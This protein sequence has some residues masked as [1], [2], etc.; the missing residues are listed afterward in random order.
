M[1]LNSS[2][3]E[4]KVYHE[5]LKPKSH[6]FSYGI[7]NFC[8]DLDELEDLSKKFLFFSNEKWNLFSFYKRDHLDF[9]RSSHKENILYFLEQNKIQQNISKIFLVTNLRVLGYT[10]NPVCFYYCYNSLNELECILIEVHNT[11]GETKPYIIQKSELQNSGTHYKREKK[12]FYVSP[13]QDLETEF[14]FIIREP[15]EKLHININDIQNNE[16]VLYA[17]IIGTRKPL[18]NW[19]LLYYF[20]RFPLVTLHIITQ[21]HF[22]A[23]LL[24]LKKIPYFKKNQ[25]LELQ[26]GVYYGKNHF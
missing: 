18:T 4:C 2:I 24:Y 8:I 13:F 11:F 22:Q 16:H 14:E 12:F 25:N 6:K 26:R 5:R 21:I 20:F 15:N 9:K 1:E 23:L 10:F 19:K 17:S 7:Y 3:Y